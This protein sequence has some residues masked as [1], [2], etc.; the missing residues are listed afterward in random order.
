MEAQKRIVKTERAVRVDYT[1]M[2]A[3]DEEVG[4][5][6]YPY[7]EKE[8]DPS[9][10][11]IREISY[12]N[13]GSIQEHYEY[14][15]DS[16]GRR[17]EAKNFYDEEEVVE[18][19]LYTYDKD[20]KPV[21]AMKT[22]ADGSE[23]AI[24]Y[25]YDDDGKL[26]SRVVVNDEGEEDESEEWKYDG[27]LEVTYEKR[28]YGEPVF[29]EMQEYDEHGRLIRVIL[30]DGPDGK[31]TINNLSYDTSGRR[32]LIEKRDE[33]GRIISVIRISAFDGEEPAEIAETAAGGTTTTRYTY[34]AQGQ[35]M[36]QQDISMD[37]FVT[38]E[39]VRSYT[40]EGLLRTT[41]VTAD[42]RGEGM[43]FRYRIEYEYQF[44]S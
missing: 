35:P 17:I 41:E 44:Y 23:E 15:Y 10:N 39:V 8:Y 38:N 30:W 4:E 18:L 11:L 20:D 42:R 25:T 19:V 34:N 29:R 3:L 27:D 28:E 9:G 13:A 43:N 24:S 40:E 2:S 7:L 14:K 22:Y 37:G 1:I 26:L 6:R 5:V 16:Q 33:Q 36:L 32:N 31:V 12:D 21:S